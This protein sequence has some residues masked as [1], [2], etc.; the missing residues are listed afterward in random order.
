MLRESP[1]K[2]P[3]FIEEALRIHAP[4]NV[5]FRAD[6]KNVRE[7]IAFRRGIHTCAGASPGSRGRS[8]SAVS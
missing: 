4:M 2:T 3:T 1:N 7:H 8:P 5:D 6:R